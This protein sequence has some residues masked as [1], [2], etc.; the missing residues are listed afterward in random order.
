VGIEPERISTLFGPFRTTKGPLGNGLGLYI[1]KEIID[2]HNGELLV[3]STVGVGTT[4]RVIFP[5]EASQQ[6]Q[7]AG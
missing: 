7:R 1:S 4:M 5:A 3:E 2:R 6:T